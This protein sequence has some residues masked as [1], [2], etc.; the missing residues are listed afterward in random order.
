MELCRLDASDEGLSVCQPCGC[1]F[2]MCAW[3]TEAPAEQTSWMCTKASEVPLLD[4]VL[5]H[6]QTGNDG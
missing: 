3:V 4:S 5:R 2:D 1:D 6:D